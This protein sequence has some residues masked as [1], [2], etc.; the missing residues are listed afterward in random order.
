[1]RTYELVVV[2]KPTL[3]ET[4]RKKVADEIKGWLKPVKI[5]HEDDLGKKSLAYAVKSEKSGYYLN[6]TM[7]TESIP[8]GFEKRLLT[9]EQVL[10]HLLLRK[11]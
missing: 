10:R 8:Q 3:S 7:E 2:L 6:Y 11:N 1:M 9:T 5:T 4:E